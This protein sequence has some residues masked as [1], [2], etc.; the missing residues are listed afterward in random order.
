MHLEMS[1]EFLHSARIYM[2]HGGR[3]IFWY[4]R[5]RLKEALFKTEGIWNSQVVFDSI[6]VGFVIVDVD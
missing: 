4:L 1:S 5:R 6:D 3:T 2:C